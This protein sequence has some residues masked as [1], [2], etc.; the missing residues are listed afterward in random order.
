MHFGR[1]AMVFI[2]F[3]GPAAPQD[4]APAGAVLLDEQDRTIRARYEQVLAR[5]PFHESAFDRVYE[6][7]M[8]AE[9]VQAWLD[10]LA[11]PDGEAAPRED[12]VL[13]G[14]ILARQL[15]TREAIDILAEVRE[16][17]ATDPDLDRLL[18][19][20]Y[21]EAGDDDRAIDLLSGTLETVENPDER[22]KLSRI[23]GNVYLRAG[24]REEAAEAWER[25]VETAPGDFFALQ[26]LAGI[27]ESNRMW[28]KAIATYETIVEEAADDPYRRCRAYQA[29]GRAHVA[30]EDYAAAIAA[31]EAG[32]DLAAPG[33]WLFEDLKDR[34]V[35][36]YETTGDL[37]GLAAYL[38]ARLA[39]NPADPGFQELLAETHMRRGDNAAAEAVLADVLARSPGRRSALEMRLR[40]HREAGSLE[41]LAA[42][43]ETLIAQYPEEPDFLRR[44]GEAY[45]QHNKPEEA[46]ATWRRVAGEEASAADHALLAEWLER[47]EFYPE[48]AEAYARALALEPDREW[49]L[50]LAGLRYDMGEE[51]EALAAWQSAVAPE[52]TPAAEIAEVAAILASRDF[53]EEARALYRR[54][55][56]RDPDNR[57]HVLA[58]ARLLAAGEAWEEALPHFE[59]LADQDENEYFKTRGEQG[60]LDAYAALGTLDE[61]RTEWEAAVA[62]HPDDPAPRLKLAR[63]YARAGNRP[64]AVKLYE[65]CAALEPENVDIQRRLAEAY[66]LNRQHGKAIAVL[67]G[68]MESDPARAGGYLRDLLALHARA[69]D[70]DAAIEAAER[71]VEMAP[72]SA[73]ARSELAGIYQRYGEQ[74]KAL[75][76]YRNVVQLDSDEPAYYRELGEALMRSER[77]GQARDVFRK[78]LEAA[79]NPTGRLDAVNHLAGVYV[80][81]GRVEALAAEFRERVRATPKN[82]AAY[83]ELAAVHRA[84]G[85]HKA[86]LETIESA[87]GEVEDR[88]AFLRRL[89]AEAHDAGDFERVVAAYEELVTL[90]GEPTV[91][92]LNRLAE[93]H[94]RT[95]DLEAAVAVWERIATENPD[96]AD[97]Q[98]LVARA[99]REHGYYEDAQTYVEAALQ[100]D[101]YDYNLRFQYAQ[102]LLNTNQAGAAEEQLRRILEIGEPPDAQPS[103]QAGTATGAA[104]PQPGRPVFR[105]SVY[106]GGRNIW[107]LTRSRI[108]PGGGP[109]SSSFHPMSPGFA[110]GRAAQ[111]F[112]AMRS[113]VLQTLVQLAQQ[114]GEPDS[115]LDEFREKVEADPNNIDA[116]F[117]YLAVCEYA[118]RNELALEAALDLAER[119][120][121]DPQLLW[122]L[123]QFQLAA[124][125]TPDAIATAMKLAGQDDDAMAAR[126]L[127]ALV[128]LHLKGDDPDAVEAAIDQLTAR[129][130]DNAGIHMQLAGTLNQAGRVEEAEEHFKKAA[131]IDPNREVQIYNTLAQFYKTRGD[132]EKAREHY[133]KVLFHDAGSAT[134]HRR[135]ATRGAPGR[136][137]VHLPQYNRRGGMHSGG[138]N[139]SRLPGANFA[140]IDHQKA[141]A[142][143]QL[144]Q[145]TLDDDALAPV[146]ERLHREAAAYVTADTAEAEQ[147]AAGYLGMYMAYLGHT[148]GAEAALAAVHGLAEEEERDLL[149]Q[150][151]QLY[152]LEQ[153]GR[154]EDM[155][156]LYDTLAEQHAIQPLQHAQARLHIALATGKVDRVA[157]FYRAYTAAGGAA[158]QLSIYVRTLEQAGAHD[159]AQA[160]LEEDLARARNPETLA[161]L[162]RVYSRKNEHDRAIELAREAW[163]RQSAGGMHPGQRHQRYRYV[164]HNLSLGSMGLEHLMPL[165]EAYEAAG[166]VDDL[167]ADFE[168]RLEGQPNAVRLH[169]ALVGLHAQNKRT[170]LAQA[171][172]EALIA[173]RPNDLALKLQY[174]GLL[175]SNGEKEAALAILEEAEARPGGRRNF[176]HEIQRLYRELNKT[177]ELAAFQDRMIAEARTP[178]QMRQLAQGFAN[179]QEFGKAADLMARAM[180]MQP[181]NDW[182]AFQAADFYWRADQRDKA[183]DTYTAYLEAADNEGQF[184]IRG[185]NLPTLVRRFEANG[186][187]DVLKGIAAQGKTGPFRAVLEARIAEHEARYEDAV[188]LLEPLLDEGGEQT[189][190]HLLLA[191]IAEKMGD[192]D[193][194]IGYMKRE[195]TGRQSGHFGRL[196]AL[197]LKKGDEE[198][199]IRFWKKQAEQQGSFH[200]HSEAIGKLVGAGAFDAAERYFLDI[201]GNIPV[202]DW[203]HRQLADLMLRNHVDEGRFG[204]RVLD[205]IFETENEHTGQLAERLAGDYH[206]H[207]LQARERLAPIAAR[208]PDNVRVQS[209]FADILTRLEDYDAAIET[210]EPV[211][212]AE[213]RNAGVF[214]KY[215]DL[216]RQA[217]RHT[218]RKAA[219]A[220][221]LLATKGPDTDLI[222][223]A[224]EI[225]LASGD[226]AE[227]ADLRDRVVAGADP[228]ERDRI[229]ADFATASGAADPRTVLRARYDANPSSEN[230]RAYLRMLHNTGYHDEAGA[231]HAEVFDDGDGPRLDMDDAALLA[232]TLIPAGHNEE[233]W[234]LL[235]DAFRREEHPQN[236]QRRL[237][238]ILTT[239][240]HYG[241]SARAPRALIERLRAEGPLTLNERMFIATYEMYMGHGEQALELLD[242]D[243]NDHRLNNAVQLIL[244]Q[245]PPE[246]QKAARES[247][248]TQTDP[249]QDAIRDALNAAREAI[250]LNEVAEAIEMLDG[251]DLAG[252]DGGHA[253][254]RARLYLDAGAYD[255]AVEH[256]RTLRERY[257]ESKTLAATLMLA[258]AGAGDFDEAMAVWRAQGQGKP[259]SE[260][261]RFA[262]RLMEH[263][264]HAEAREIIEAFAGHPDR[265]INADMLLARL[266]HETGDGEAIV[267]AMESRY[268]TLFGDSRDRFDRHYESFLV[269]T[270]RWESVLDQAAVAENEAL[271]GA[272]LVAADQ[273]RDDDATPN[274]AASIANALAG[275]TWS[276]PSQVIAYSNLLMSLGRQDD[277]IAALRAGVDAARQDPR[278]LQ[279]IARQLSTLDAHAEAAAILNQFADGYPVLLRD[280]RLIIY[281]AARAEDDPAAESLFEKLQATSYPEAQQRY[282]QA[283]LAFERDDEAAGFE[284]YRALL[285]A[286]GA[287]GAWL[288]IIA[289]AFLEEGLHEEGRRALERL[290]E[291]GAFP[292]DEADAAGVRLVTLLMETGQPLEAIRLFGDLL[293]A[294]R[295]HVREAWAA[296]LN[297]AAE[298]PWDEAERLIM[299][300]VTAEP[301]HPRVPRLLALRS[302]IAAAQGR[303]PEPAD[304]EAL[305]LPAAQAY[306]TR[307]RTGLIDAWRISPPEPVPAWAAM[308]APLD[309]GLKALLQGNADHGVALHEWATTGP[310]DAASAV[311]MARATESLSGGSMH[312]GA[313]YAVVEIESPDARTIALAAGSDDWYRVWVN[314]EEVLTNAYNRVCILDQDR[315]EA[316]LHE[317]RNRILVKCGKV[318]GDWE[319][320]LSIVENGEGL[321]VRLP[322]ADRIAQGS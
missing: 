224:T 99:L 2:L 272:L 101:P 156:A 297:G 182:M 254:H 263:E 252:E 187:L 310:A 276:R 125:R 33:N 184:L 90:A 98:L 152:F 170:D 176:A 50:R 110:S 18:G 45:L 96:D 38:D 32:L 228:S 210:L 68:L 177:E 93:A 127:L 53:P 128:S 281:L 57:D 40:L 292:M 319:F 286:P 321:T 63:L 299:E 227:L 107:S 311:S 271:A 139:Y 25:I 195:A 72:S 157:E 312:R 17:G 216:L 243:L 226:R 161:S 149:L 134:L 159:I 256:A 208:F 86:A 194:A 116:R 117:D 223:Q 179:D 24:R 205:A 251:L 97:A 120:P 314:G 283:Q 236:A 141:Q 114:A 115:V 199:A 51:E 143:N 258:L 278:A 277:A 235:F 279:N 285:D 10:K 39:E 320:A 15:K 308:A 60:L 233:A 247:G 215:L 75:Q 231:F 124:D 190:I 206:R 181:G 219:M 218:E 288:R 54:A 322:P 4:A 103:Q 207:P 71:L 289:A 266:L 239:M 269:S 257:P 78:M 220:E 47:Y 304:P 133:A 229:V 260:A 202:G 262:E 316:T 217:G 67:E 212:E 163:Q 21:Y 178:D 186:R 222:E 44:L 201:V 29:I 126:A 296:I 169:R 213:P 166:R 189:Q 64:D 3:A 305:G 191:E 313:A 250:R 88:N 121:A 6:G 174:A 52:D 85:D 136:P 295:E 162:A 61:R 232:R 48:A 22:A 59:Q 294:R 270:G 122:R 167:I 198:N 315:V 41:E 95:G 242:I 192:L 31:F 106:S 234:R 12:R 5:D 150:N 175:E 23:L 74:D 46:L 92:E 135:H 77:L 172:M 241:V 8:L 129:A 165:W 188:R 203:A 27:Y 211:L 37:D 19:R 58:Y 28:E 81:L 209:R 196:A 100:I 267:P 142:L 193:A 66:R 65:E 246:L 306:E 248:N 26:E 105:P 34:L 137:A 55:I 287:D 238:T 173:T 183:L 259:D 153:L 131:E 1:I 240:H 104:S 35:A 56:N 84:A 111:N 307:L 160:L 255:Q 11:P 94:A 140:A 113:Q 145:M 280:E 154:Y 130:P 284:H 109:W 69:N 16:A 244:H 20:L 317:G 118:G 249:G 273:V 82:L 185:S 80:R 123:L 301:G 237:G 49:R 265:D 298:I 302:R 87:R 36:V 197:Y 230:L 268:K 132:V 42:T 146:L 119:Y 155:A 171:Q 225:F 79:T 9:G 245:M 274:P 70:R 221:H 204:T 30:R 275:V 102:E 13:R 180:R 83:E 148:A 253:V 200:G 158:N 168:S 164:R 318:R 14:R 264:R 89:L 282:H 43:F 138:G 290:R 76:Q 91:Y 73:E 291:P 293:P 112:E 303:D 261:M 214:R 147:R 309:E 300:R 144:V 7:Y 151:F 108:T 62:A